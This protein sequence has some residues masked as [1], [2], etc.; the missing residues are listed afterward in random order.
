MLNESFQDV[1]VKKLSAYL[2]KSRIVQLP[3]EIKITGNIANS[4]S[5]GQLDHYI[6]FWLCYNGNDKGSAT[7]SK[8][9]NNNKSL[10]AEYTEYISTELQKKF[11]FTKDFAILNKRP[12]YFMIDSKKSILNRF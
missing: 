2:T 12:G 7:R 1:C 5:E 11:T 4:G 10:H 6:S 3:V 9:I 8:I